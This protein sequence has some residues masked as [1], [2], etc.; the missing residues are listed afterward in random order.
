MQRGG[1]E[2]KDGE[3]THKAEGREGCQKEN[4][5]S[6]AARVEEVDA[7]KLNSSDSYRGKQLPPGMK[8]KKR[9]SDEERSSHNANSVEKM[10][11]KVQE[12]T[13]EQREAEKTVSTSSVKAVHPVK[14][15]QPSQDPHKDSPQQPTKG[16]T[17]Q[18][19][20]AVKESVSKSAP[21]S[22]TQ[23]NT[24]T[25]PKQS[26]QTKDAAAAADDDDVVV[27][28]VK[29]ATQ[30]TP[31]VTAVQKTLTTFAGFQPASKVKGQ[32]E[33]LRGLLTAQLQQ[34]KVSKRLTVT[35]TIGCL[36]RF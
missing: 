16:E 35:G 12:K 7:G 20:A 11:E 15:N 32:Q 14:V 29:P 2:E 1:S 23:D 33:G 3:A 17:C 5:E 18:V 8:V 4:V 21:S 36:G 25:R 30:K 10:T 26:S 28:S 9:V 31:P 22:S 19:D 27:V 34:K 24:S 6:V 13:K